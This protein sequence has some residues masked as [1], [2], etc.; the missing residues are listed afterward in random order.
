MLRPPLA[1]LRWK[2][3]ADSVWRSGWLGVFFI[4]AAA[5]WITW[6]HY[7]TPA[8]GKA[9]AALAVA[10]A[11]MSLRPEATG[12][13]RSAWMLI[14]GA[15][16]FVELRA[17]DKDRS[18]NAREQQ[19]AKTAED[20]RFA[21]S[22]KQNQN[23]FKATMG[24]M[25]HLDE[26]SRENIDEV[27]GG[28]DYIVVDIISVPVDK[29][30][31]SLVAV[32]SGRHVIRGV[33]Y[34]LNEGRPPYLPSDKQ[35]NEIIAGRTPE[36][37]IMGQLG[38][39]VPAISTPVRVMHPPLSTGGYYNINVTAINGMTNEKLEVRIR[40]REGRVEPKTHNNEGQRCHPKARLVS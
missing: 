38:E 40:A 16:L 22:L 15:F 37:T 14:I 6:W 26:L 10:A 18:E 27:T 9:V 3:K 13:E 39:I 12:I 21:E 32:T 36:G 2:L 35:L 28:N 34:S 33:R 5:L 4:V 1:F 29:D 24:R 19:E 8:P 25:E 17:I 31:V 11:I 23:E 7:H 20:A 30:G